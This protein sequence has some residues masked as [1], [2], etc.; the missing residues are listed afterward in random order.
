M[1]T[2]SERQLFIQEI[3]HVVND[4]EQIS[5]IALDCDMDEMSSDSSQSPAA[6][7]SDSSSSSSSSCS[8]SSSSSSSSGSEG[9]LSFDGTDTDGERTI[10]MGMTID[11]LHVKSCLLLPNMVLADLKQAELVNCWVLNGRSLM[12]KRKRYISLRVFNL[13]HLST[14]HSF[15]ALC[16]AGCA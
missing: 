5:R 4:L 16:R 12:M 6:S 15:A 11:L 9:F 10:I 1:P 3:L 7:E 13:N 14:H 2:I 8:S